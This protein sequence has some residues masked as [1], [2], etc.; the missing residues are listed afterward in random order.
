MHPHITGADVPHE[1][2]LYDL[3]SKVIPD[4]FDPMELTGLQREAT[5]WFDE[6]YPDVNIGTEKIKQSEA[7]NRCK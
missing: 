3:D 7:T 6:T 5:S 4:Y 2:P 1:D